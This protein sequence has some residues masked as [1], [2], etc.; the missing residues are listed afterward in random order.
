[1]LHEQ[2]TGFR[3][4]FLYLL[5]ELFNIYIYRTVLQTA[6][7]RYQ[8]ELLSK[9]IVLIYDFCFNICRKLSVIRYYK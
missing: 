9:K 1:M 2:Y 4:I 8:N 5:A 7:L 6:F 3:L